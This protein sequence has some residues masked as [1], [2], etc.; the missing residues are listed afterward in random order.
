MSGYRQDRRDLPGTSA[1]HMRREPDVK[2]PLRPIGVTG[3]PGTRRRAVEQSPVT[4]FLRD[5]GLPQYAEVLRDH[6]FD[7]METL[8]GMEEE[9]MRD[10]GMPSGHVVKLKRRLREY[11][12]T[13]GSKSAS[14]S[15]PP[16]SSLPRSMPGAT[17]SLN[18]NAMTTVQMSWM[19]VKQL[20]TETVGGLFYKKFFQI[21][22]N[23]KALFPLSVRMRYK[24]WDTDEEEGDD[25]TNSP[26][27]RKLWA[28]FITVVGS[29]VAGIQDCA[30]LV[31]NLQ[32]LGVRHVSYGLKAEYLNIAN[33]VL[34]EVLSEWLGESFTKEVENA[35][36]MVS[37]FMIATMM[38][39]YKAACT[40]IQAKQLHL[41][42]LQSRKDAPTTPGSCG[43][44]SVTEKQTRLADR[45]A[46][47]SKE[48]SD[49]EDPGQL[50]QLPSL[51]TSGGM[52]SPGGFIP[53]DQYARQ[54]TPLTSMGYLPLDDSMRQTTPFALFPLEETL[55]DVLPFA[56]PINEKICQD[57][58]VPP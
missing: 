7:D 30:K 20:G 9:H 12:Q 42:A 2:P 33:K 21:E 47:D 25:P 22:P 43:G 24:D 13:S 32:T 29:A 6:G 41:A 58:P 51:L 53:L 26:A 36:V 48:A 50:P 49:G 37:G 46:E 10:A 31:P 11:A 34:I 23:A 45:E 8:L 3:A 18:N 27:L 56:P 35:W 57:S 40:E 16:A 15:Q 55:R 19:Q 28:K 1:R 44:S 52:P 17:V 14:T 4:A 5:V 54:K 39:G 38:A